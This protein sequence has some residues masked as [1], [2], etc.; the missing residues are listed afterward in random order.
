MT[1]VQ[2]LR[3]GHDWLCSLSPTSDAFGK[4]T[5]PVTSA[6]GSNH[7]NSFSSTSGGWRFNIKVSAGLNFLRPLFL[8]CREPLSHSKKWGWNNGLVPNWK[9]SMSRLYIVTLSI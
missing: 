1:W 9:R 7:G 4:L 6:S 3:A 5:F 2:E 8:V